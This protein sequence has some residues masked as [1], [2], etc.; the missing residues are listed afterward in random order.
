MRNNY[1]ILLVSLTCLIACKQ[2]KKDTPTNTFDATNT[3]KYAK[4]L[5]V[6][7]HSNYTIIK[8][9]N[10]WPDAEKGFTYLLTKD[11][12]KVPSN[13]DFDAVVQTP[14][15]SI[16]VTSTT[17]IPALEALGVEHALVGFPST[18]YISS[19][20][21]R[22]LITNGHVKELGANELINTEVLIDLQPDVVVGFSINS[23]NKTYNTIEKSGIPVVYNGD[24]TEQTPLGKAEWVKFFAPFFEKETLADSIFNTIETE[25]LK[26]KQ[27][28]QKATNAPTA[29]SGSMFKDVWY[30]PAGESWGAQFLKDANIDYLWKD[31][32]GTGSLSLSFET[33]LEKGSMASIWIGPGSFTTNQQLLD[34]N[35]HYQQFK[36]FKDQQIYTFGLTQGETGGM[37]YY[38]LAP[39]RPDLVLKDLVKIA[40]PHL[41]PEYQPFFFKPIQ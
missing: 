40:H 28:A 20:K 36:A 14:I 21:T 1:F 11:Q 37:L 22:K 39:N 8:V 12:K 31:S 26:A 24:W 29:L 6:E 30:V 41:L 27:I 7:K 19:K 23:Q 35:E 33:V 15:K 10:P 2:S 18:N 25:Y 5:S 3:I 4:G 13:I 32:K 16:V 38:E 9:T 17:H 34:A